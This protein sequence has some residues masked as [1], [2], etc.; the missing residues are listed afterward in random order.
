LCWAGL[1]LSNDSGEILNP[2]YGIDV[3]DLS[4]SLRRMNQ[5]QQSIF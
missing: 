2:F 3:P 4:Y 5:W 1:S